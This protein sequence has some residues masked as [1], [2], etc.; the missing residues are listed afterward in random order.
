MRFSTKGLAAVITI[1]AAWLKNVN[2]D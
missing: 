2:W 1:K